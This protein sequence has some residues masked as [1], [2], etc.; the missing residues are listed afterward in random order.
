M[1]N[2]S[3]RDDLLLPYLNALN[4]K[5]FG[6][7]MGKFKSIMLDKLA[8]QGGM[9]NLSK[10]SNFY[11]AGAVRYYFNGDL[12][13]NKKLSVLTGDP[14]ATDNWNTEVCKRLDVLIDTLRNSYIDSIGTTYEQPED[15]G[16]LPVAKLLTKYKRRIDKV[17]GIESKNPKNKPLPEIDTNPHVGNGY[18]FDILYNYGEAT[19]YERYTA[20]GSWCITYGLGHYEHYI[21][22]LNCHYVIFL[23]DGYQ[24]VQRRVGPGYTPNKPHDEYGNSMIAFLQSNNSWQPTYITSRWNHGH[25]SDHTSGTEAD[26]AYT[27]DEFCQIT[28]VSKED[29]QRIYTIW[30]RNAP[31]EKDNDKS[32]TKEHKIEV[33]RQLK[34]AQMR[35]NGGEY[36]GNFLDP[37]QFFY[38]KMPQSADKVK[39]N[40][41][42]LA[43]KMKNNTEMGDAKFIVDKGRIVFETLLENPGWQTTMEASEKYY[44]NTWGNR[45]DEDEKTK[46]EGKMRN[47]IIIKGETGGFM[48]YDVRKHG[49]VQ[50]GGTKKF[51]VIPRKWSSAYG[52]RQM[53]AFYE[54]KNTIREIVLVSTLTNQPLRLPNG[55][56]WINDVSS[57]TMKSNRDNYRNSLEAEF[58]G[59]VEDNILE[60]VYDDSSR[61][62]YF[63]DVRRRKFVDVPKT[64]G[65]ENCEVCYMRTTSGIDRKYAKFCEKAMDSNYCYAST[66]NMF[67]LDENLK[68]VNMGGIE[69][70]SNISNVLGADGTQYFAV[71]PNANI[72][73]DIPFYN[74]KDNVNTC[75]LYDAKMN[76]F[77][78]IDGECVY[79]NSMITAY[80]VKEEVLRLKHRVA[81][82]TTS[83]GSIAWKDLEA[84]YNTHSHGII[85][86]PLNYPS[87]YFFDVVNFWSSPAPKIRAF[88]KKTRYFSYDER[89]E[90]NPEFMEAVNV[91]YLLDLPVMRMKPSYS[92]NA[93][94]SAP[95]PSLAEQSI[96]ETDIRQMV[97]ETLKKIMGNGKQ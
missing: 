48:L 39:Y 12:T 97:S 75:I 13:R 9:H 65:Y 30:K 28:G 20:P 3:K 15:F 36:P 92:I 96:N 74:P 51:K 62:K 61:E 52:S 23:K 86:N 53:P 64:P 90:S 22:S 41:C 68:K 57:Q 71:T 60:L 17:L 73:K 11:L 38:G 59:T 81:D 33:L 32:A 47:I 19:K 80:S 37:V 58:V 4:E 27:L 45:K 76:D 44:N 49:F 56:Y 94:Q 7:S 6:L 63:Y 72:H 29:L 10:A 50:V 8:A 93:A 70:F 89:K 95:A 5:G 16:T 88:K 42:V 1:L 34:Y 77:V 31:V 35:I 21:R 55:E 54:L 79:F 87:E 25:S 78:K 85:R 83:Y 91:F 14:A 24:N 18:T 84:F 69:N 40:D 66:K 2:E 67:V 82:G 26:H 46:N 43:C